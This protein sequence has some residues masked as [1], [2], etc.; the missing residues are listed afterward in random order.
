MLHTLIH[1]HVHLTRR[2]S[3][4]ILGNFETTMLLI[5]SRGNGQKSTLTFHSPLNIVINEAAVFLGSNKSINRTPGFWDLTLRRRFL[6]LRRNVL[7]YSRIFL[8]SLRTR[9]A[10]VGRV[11]E[12]RGRDKGGKKSKGK[13]PGKSRRKRYEEKDKIEEIKT[14]KV[15]KKVIL[16]LHLHARHIRITSLHKNAGSHCCG[17][18]KCFHLTRP[19]RCLV[20]HMLIIV[21]MNVIC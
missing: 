3:G 5:M 2:T 6:A 9:K 14:E 12:Q 13:R 17:I 19:R 16:L 4:R 18:K 20:Y 1:P 21:H 8:Y 10:R 15:K 7:S 11:T